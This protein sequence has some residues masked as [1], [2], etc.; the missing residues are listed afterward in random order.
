[1]ARPSSDVAPVQVGGPEFS[2]ALTSLWLELPLR[3]AVVRAPPP[4]GG[5][6]LLA[7]ASWVD[8]A[9]RSE[10]GRAYGGY[11]ARRDSPGDCLSLFE[12][13]P[14][15]RDEDK[16]R[17]A[18][19]LAVGPVLEGLDTELRAVLDPTRVLATLSVSLVAYMGLLLMPEPVSKGLAAA[20]TVLMWGYLGWEFFDLL[21][22]YARL[23]DEA[24][25]AERFAQLRE[26]GER[27]GRVVG[28]NTVRIL[29]MVGTV[30][31]GDAAA[32]VARAPRLPG[33]GQA[34][35][36]VE[37]GTGLGV[38]EVVAGAER[39]L[40]SVPEGSLSLVLAPHVVAM[41]SRSA[42]AGS[43]APSRGR[44]LSNG[45]RAWGSYSGFKSAM[46]PAGKGKQWH[47]VVEQTPGNAKRFGG[48][49]LHNTENVMALDETLHSRLS[50]LYSMK[51]FRIT[52]SRTWT[53]RQWLSTQSYE[54]QREFG[55]L[56]IE[57]VRSGVWP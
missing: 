8:E 40:V 9:W 26:V 2:A 27:F 5:R 36:R 15:W 25:R 43:S 13:G 38:L 53:V 52:S 46:G 22:A 54:A 47:H 55:L 29:V 31:L 30:A 49:A 16:R 44:L 34:A 39:V 6:V 4:V 32:F 41:A 7:S 50:A 3:V 19:A 45:H 12:D 11:C 17:L 20:F 35:A 24:P 57:N 23:H 56:A 48:E 14:H 51:F 37:V 21:R 28:P 1:M 42:P 18:L 10:L 33:F